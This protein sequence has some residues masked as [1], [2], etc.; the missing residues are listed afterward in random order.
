MKGF[1][2]VETIIVMGV[3]TAASMGTYNLINNSR[4]GFKELEINMEVQ[5]LVDSIRTILLDKKSCNETFLDAALNT[6][7]T[8]IKRFNKNTA[9][10]ENTYEA[11]PLRKYANDNLSIVSMTPKSESGRNYLLLFISKLK[12]KNVRDV[13][14]EIDMKF[15]LSGS[16]ITGCFADYS[17]NANSNAL[18]YTCT[19][20]GSTYDSATQKCS[21][22][23]KL[24]NTDMYLK[25]SNG[26]WKPINTYI[27]DAV[28][29]IN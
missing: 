14:Q 15:V 19:Q 10:F 7:I 5:S 27:I 26:V 17:T 22:S 21:T 18:S 23:F 9:L 2:L 12:L 3:M 29:G 28:N 13:R 16:N 4:K 8:F 1:S 25:D 24:N 6:P 11:N 20:L